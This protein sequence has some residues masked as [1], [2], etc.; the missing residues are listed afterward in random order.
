[1]D[2]ERLRMIDSSATEHLIEMN[3][4]AYLVDGDR[5]V[6]TRLDTDGSS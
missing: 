6:W 2:G 4:W 5:M 3:G 1:M